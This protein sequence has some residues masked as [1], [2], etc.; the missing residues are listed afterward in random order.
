MY[1]PRI[2]RGLIVMY[3]HVVTRTRSF[4]IYTLLLLLLAEMVRFTTSSQ[5]QITLDVSSVRMITMA[6]VY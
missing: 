2:V 4:P 3:Y 5:F 1:G 6:T